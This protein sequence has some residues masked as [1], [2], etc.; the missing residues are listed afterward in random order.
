MIT[1]ITRLNFKLI[2]IGF[3]ISIQLCWCV[4]VGVF[5]YFQNKWILGSI[6][7]F[8]MHLLSFF[9]PIFVF[10]IIFKH[11]SNNG[12]AIKNVFTY[13]KVT[14]A[15]VGFMKVFY[16]LL[17]C[18]EYSTFP[19]SFSVGLGTILSV[20]ITIPSDRL[21]CRRGVGSGQLRQ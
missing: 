14:L 4:F 18:M 2:I 10:G 15:I 11:A 9:S 12:L 21:S 16:G 1:S 13:I 6:I 7:G 8:V 3:L 20:V 5:D 17:N 19:L